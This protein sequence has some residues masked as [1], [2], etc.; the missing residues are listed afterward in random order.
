MQKQNADR[1]IVDRD[2]GSVIAF[3]AK[4]LPGM[5][6]YYQAVPEGFKRPSMFFPEPEIDSFSNTL[7]SFGLTYTLRAHF[8]GRNAWEGQRNASTVL[9]Q[10]AR[11]RFNV[12]VLLPTGEQTS[13][14]LDLSQPANIRQTEDRPGAAILTVT[15]DHRELYPEMEAEKIRHVHLRTRIKEPPIYDLDRLLAAASAE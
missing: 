1:R 9:L 14:A 3:M 11:V 5:P 12:P 13:E 7:T 10:I 8:F 6:C 15:W 4:A 2:T